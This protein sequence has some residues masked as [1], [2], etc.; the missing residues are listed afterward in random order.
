MTLEEIKTLKH[1]DLITVL[2]RNGKFAGKRVIAEFVGYKKVSYG[3]YKMYHFKN[4]EYGPGSIFTASQE[5]LL[6]NDYRI[7]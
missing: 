4:L 5:D 1:E 3:D 7:H 6:K 2:C